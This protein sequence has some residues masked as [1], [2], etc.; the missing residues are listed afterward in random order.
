MRLIG[1]IPIKI[2]NQKFVVIFNPLTGNCFI[3]K[4]KVNNLL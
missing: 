1:L 3:A 2:E 4:A